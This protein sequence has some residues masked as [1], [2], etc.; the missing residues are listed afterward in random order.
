MATDLTR[1]HCLSRFLVDGL[2][3]AWHVPGRIV[4][5]G[6]VVS[7]DDNYDRLGYEPAAVTRDA[8]YTR[9]VSETALLPQ[10]HQR[11]RALRVASPGGGLG[12][13]CP[14]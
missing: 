5:S 7:V 11:R 6:R 9:Y 4:R 1:W 2:A 10:P 8:Q 3:E 14:G 12:H 13:R